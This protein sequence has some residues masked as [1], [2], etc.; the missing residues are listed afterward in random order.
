MKTKFNPRRPFDEDYPRG[1]YVE[2]NKDF[3]DNNFELCVEYLEKLQEEYEH[4]ME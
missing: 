4:E 1:D 3:V 2:S